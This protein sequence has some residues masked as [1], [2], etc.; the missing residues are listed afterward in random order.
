MVQQRHEIYRTTH[1]ALRHMMFSTAHK[2]GIA[3]FRD[4]TEARDAITSLERTINLLVIHAEHENNYIHPDLEKRAPG[5]IAPYETDH[6]NDEKVHAELRRLGQE[7][8]SASGDQKVAL[9][10]ELYDRFN[11]YIGDYLGHLVREESELQQALWDNFTDGELDTMVGRLI[12]NYPPDLRGEILTEV[13]AALNADELTARLGRMKAM[14]PPG[15]F[16]GVIKIAEQAAT[17]SNFE[18]VRA[19]LT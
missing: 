11:S 4:D 14:A 13:C 18:K 9:G 19:R 2:L 10:I 17:P 16:E 5:L 7:A 15:R 8:N 12:A 3:D 6:Q 1:K